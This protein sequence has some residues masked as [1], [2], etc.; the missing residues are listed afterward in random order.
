MIG[1]VLRAGGPL[2]HRPLT[3]RTDDPT[4]LRENPRGFPAGPLKEFFARR[5]L[6]FPPIATTSE[7]HGGSSH[8]ATRSRERTVEP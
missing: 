2:I 1:P 6:L 7:E 4:R 3:Q 5:L 8:E